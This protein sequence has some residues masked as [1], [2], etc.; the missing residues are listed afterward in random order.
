MKTTLLDSAQVYAH[1]VARLPPSPMNV[2]FVA[3]ANAFARL[4]KAHAIERPYQTQL[5][6]KRELVAS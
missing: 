6:Y 3:I 4:I 1:R 2:V 5:N